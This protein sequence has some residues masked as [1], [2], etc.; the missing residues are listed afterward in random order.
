MA[1]TSHELVTCTVT[2]G[3]AHVRLDRPDKLNALTLETL[4]QLVAT[5]PCARWCSR[6]KARR[7]VPGSTSAR[8]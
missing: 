8:S 1:D 4:D 2:D 5:A 6:A 3:I 7:S